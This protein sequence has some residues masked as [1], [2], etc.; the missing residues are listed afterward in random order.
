MFVRPGSG[1]HLEGHSWVRRPGLAHCAPVDEHRVRHV[2][3]DASRRAT[4]QAEDTVARKLLAQQ[5]TVRHDS[6]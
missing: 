1:S 2:A 3:Y 4:E 6:A 5:F